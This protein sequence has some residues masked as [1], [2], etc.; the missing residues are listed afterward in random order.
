MFINDFS[1]HTFIYFL[2][3]KSEVFGLFL[4]YKALMEKQY[5]NQLQRLRTYN[6]GV[7]SVR[8]ANIQGIS[9][10]WIPN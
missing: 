10:I 4:A 2:K 8:P 6:G 7:D 1:K 9:P 3:I 5:E